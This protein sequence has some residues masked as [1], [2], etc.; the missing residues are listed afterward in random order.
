MGYDP[1]MR[2]RL[3]YPKWSKLP[4]Q[5]EF[6]L[7]P[8]G[9]VVFAAAV[10]EEHEV[11]FTDENREPVDLDER[12]DLVC[13]SMMLT[14]QVPRGLAIADGFRARGVPVIAGGIATALHA[15]EVAARV[16]A[17]FIG[18]VE[19]RFEAVLEDLTAGRLKRVYDYLEHPAPIAAVGTARR[20]ILNRA[21]YNYRGVQMP[22]LVHASRGCRFDCYPC[23]VRYLGGR[24]FRPRPIEQVVAEVEAIPNTKLFFVDNS[25]AQDREWELALFEALAPLKRHIIS[26]PIE[27]DDEVLDAAARAGAWWVYQAVFDTSDFIAGRIRRLKQRGIFVEGTVLLG[28]DDHDADF[29]KRLVD[30]LLEIELDLAEFTVL[31]PFPH[32]RTFDELEA[33]GR[34]LHED[35]SRYTAGEVVFRPARMTPDELQGMYQYA[36]DA[37]HAHES[38][39]VRMARVLRPVILADRGGVGTAAGI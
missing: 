32:T 13:L 7:P 25:L 16:D 22:D 21:Q 9:P 12:P 29:I 6:H 28:L 38:Q 36:W 8:H 23:C 4:N 2:I 30:F 20:S 18:E 39:A 34:I 24:S 5:R 26:H 31:T 10:P 27:D 11:S 19:G 33:Q 3:I 35:W 15:E 1:R 17:A 14:C 37:F